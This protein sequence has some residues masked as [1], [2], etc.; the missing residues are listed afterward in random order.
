MDAHR[1][2]LL[3]VVY[4]YHRSVFW[5][6]GCPAGR[7][8]NHFLNWMDVIRMK[9]KSCRTENVYI[10]T[11]RQMKV[12]NPHPHSG[13]KK[14][15]ALPGRVLSGI[16]MSITV[17]ILDTSIQSRFQIDSQL[18]R[19]QLM[20]GCNNCS[21]NGGRLVNRLE[22]YCVCCSNRGSY[23]TTIWHLISFDV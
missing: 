20:A 4:L 19:R 8:L 21:R 14:S 13:R 18:D 5:S 17:D 3:V 10:P 22:S 7:Y 11:I 2:C 15:C 23:F 12:S 16:S 1:M 9:K 6:G